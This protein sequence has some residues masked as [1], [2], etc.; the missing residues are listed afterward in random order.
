ME[1]VVF[2]GLW[3]EFCPNL[4]A[5]QARNV[6]TAGAEH[7]IRA[8][9][10]LLT[11]IWQLPARAREKEKVA[12]ANG[13][14]SVHLRIARPVLPSALRSRDHRWAWSM[15]APR[16]TQFARDGRNGRIVPKPSSDP[17]QLQS[18]RA[19]EATRGALPTQ[20]SVA[21]SFQ[22]CQ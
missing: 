21:L 7:Q 19:F 17:Q 11:D 13:L 1:C 15:K 9:T 20:M 14:L 3:C 22:C 2:S 6:T 12:G 18:S 5:V 16:T 10:S 4:D 8:P